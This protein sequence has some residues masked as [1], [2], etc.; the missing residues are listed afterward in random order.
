MQQRGP[1]PRRQVVLRR[2]RL[3]SRR[4]SPRLFYVC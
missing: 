2:L 4:P 3:S 1:R